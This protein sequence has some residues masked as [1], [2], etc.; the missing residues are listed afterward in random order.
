[1]SQRTL[2]ARVS[3]AAIALAG[4]LALTLPGVANAAEPAAPPPTLT[5]Q[6]DGDTIV[7]K[8]APPAGTTG[9]TCLPVVLSATDALPFSVAPP[10]DL[11]S[12]LP[13]LKGGFPYDVDADG[14]S[15][16]D[17]LEPGAYAVVGACLDGLSLTGYTYKVLFVPGGFGSIGQALTLGSQ[18]IALEDGIE[19]LMSQISSGAGSALLTDNL[20]ISSMSADSGDGGGSS[21]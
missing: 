16:T 8:V 1:M 2:L 20:N 19:I 4:A 11:V 21:S 5:A 10:T 7:M 14:N 6:V 17:A 18:T 12:L 3:T 9:L 13:K 15:V